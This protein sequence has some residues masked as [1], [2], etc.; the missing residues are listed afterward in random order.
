MTLIEI[1]RQEAAARSRYYGVRERPGG[2]PKL[3]DKRHAA[4]M[5]TTRAAIMVR[6]AQGPSTTKSLSDLTRRKDGTILEILFDMKAE[7][8]ITLTEKGNIKT[9]ALAGSKA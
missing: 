4:G 3:A 6:L 7:A 9:W 1:A 8:L 2:V 5:H